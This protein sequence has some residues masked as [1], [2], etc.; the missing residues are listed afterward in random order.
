MP[1]PREGEKEVR[2]VDGGGGR[3]WGKM[4]RRGRRGEEGEWGCRTQATGSNGPGKAKYL[5]IACSDCLQKFD[6]ILKRISEMS[7]SC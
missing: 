2:Y 6:K 1:D 3:G 7:L 4:G 5:N